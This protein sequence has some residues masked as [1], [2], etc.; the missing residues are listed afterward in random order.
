MFVENID[1]LTAIGKLF[2]TYIKKMSKLLGAYLLIAF[3]GLLVFSI[4]DSFLAWFYIDMIGWN[5][6]ADLETKNEF[7]NVILTFSSIFTFTLIA[8][9]VFAAIGLTYYSIFEMITAKSLKE[10]IATIGTT[11]KI[12]GLDREA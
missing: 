1:P 10:K 4:L 2:T 12:R 7:L 6:N 9:A 11:K 8:L 3:T 5:I